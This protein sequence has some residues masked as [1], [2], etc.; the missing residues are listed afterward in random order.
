MY[1]ED[2]VNFDLVKSR[3]SVRAYQARPIAADVK[4]ELERAVE[5]ENSASGLAIQLVTNEPEAFGCSFWAHYGKFSDV[6]D[7]FA[8]VGP[9]DASESL[10]FHGEGLVLEAQRLG[11]NTCWVGLS[12]NKSHVSVNVPEGMKIHALIALG[13]GV[14]SGPERKLRPLSK[15]APG[16]DEA[17]DWFK[18]AMEWV[19]PCPSAINQQ[20]F[21]FRYVDD[22]TVKATKGIGPYSAMDLG[23]AK[24]HFLLGCYPRKIEFIR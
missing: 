18:R 13:Y 4:A 21:R 9:K 19:T 1:P 10:G 14:T 20:K 17:P 22:H 11:L 8:L 16:V 5:Y 15:L 7:Y 6:T 23:I 12:Y 3:H 2:I 24:R